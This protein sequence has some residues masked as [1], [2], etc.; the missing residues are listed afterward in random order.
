MSL[1]VRGVGGG[2]SCS[3]GHTWVVGPRGAAGMSL[4]VGEGGELRAEGVRKGFRDRWWRGG[5]LLLL[6]L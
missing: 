2:Y 3:G 6:G 1:Q 5:V 4:Q